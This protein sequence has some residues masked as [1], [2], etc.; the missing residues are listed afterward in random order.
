MS[1][2]KKI[3]FIIIGSLIILA[4]VICF[5]IKRSQIPKYPPQQ[6]EVKPAEEMIYPENG[7]DIEDAIKR[8]NDENRKN[9][10]EARQAKE[11]KEMSKNIGNIPDGHYDNN[12]IVCGDCIDF[13]DGWVKYTLKDKGK[14]VYMIVNGNKYKVTITGK[15]TV[16]TIGDNQYKWQYACTPDEIPNL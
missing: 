11:D 3:I 6:E 16:L 8:V 2:K 9:L 10:E 5:S 15:G 7:E 13:G 4:L 14:N 1:N 12:L